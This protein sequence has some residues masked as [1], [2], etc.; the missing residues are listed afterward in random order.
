MKRFTA[1]IAM[2]S[3][4]LFLLTGSMNT[5]KLQAAIKDNKF[6]VVI[7][8]GHGGKDPGAIGRFSREKNINLAVAKKLGQLIKNNCPDVRVIYTRETDIF[9]PL[10]K[11][12][13]IANK[14]DAN[15]FISIHTNALPGKRIAR[16]TETY[17]LGMAR[18]DANLEVA[19]R[20][21]SVILIE[22]DYKERYEGFDPNS[23]ESYIIFE[24]MQD[25]YMAQSVD[26]AKEVQKEFRTT[27]G[28]A[29]KGVHQ[30]GFLV[31]RQTSMPSILIELGYISTHDEESYLNSQNGIN[32]L[33]QSIYNAFISYK[34]KYGTRTG[35]PVSEESGNE[36]SSPSVQNPQD[37]NSDISRLT[38][39]QKET[40]RPKGNKSQANSQPVYKVQ[41]LTSSRQLRNGSAQMKGLEHIDF[42]KEDNL[43]KYTCGE[44]TNYE[45]ARRLKNKIKEKFNGA[46]IIAFL[47]GQKIPL[48][49]AL[50]LTNRNK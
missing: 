14:A 23:S 29:D 42:Y 35:Q 5:G 17:T 2:L 27:A 25:K 33:G 9:V 11:R 1:F 13:D 12:A 21:N 4:I 15:L 20:E 6:T 28:R 24:F 34:K 26:L 10:D 43:Y 36:S 48:Q 19:K 50:D 39:E 7:D 45:E 38:K 8:P 18:A 44:T 16:G 49:K 40:E 41:F 46:F 37:D 32:K 22:S 47:N 3:A 31:L 30:A